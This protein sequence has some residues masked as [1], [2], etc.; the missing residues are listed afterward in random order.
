M[1]GIVDSTTDKQAALNLLIPALEAYSNTMR[2]A[3]AE[4]L[5]N[6]GA[7]EAEVALQTALAEEEACFVARRMR[8][9][10]RRIAEH[11][12]AAIIQ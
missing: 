6:L 8:E 5:G 4:A 10:L 11:N 9:A 3:A 1:V 12:Q 2:G 7:K